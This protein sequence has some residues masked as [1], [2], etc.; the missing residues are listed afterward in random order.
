MEWANKNKGTTYGTFFFHKAVM[1]PAWPDSSESG[2][3]KYI[4]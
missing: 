3:D 1:V 4:I 2:I